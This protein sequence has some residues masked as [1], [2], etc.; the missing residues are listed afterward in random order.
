MTTT[1]IFQVSAFS[2]GQFTG[3]PAAV[4]PLELWLPDAVMQGIAAEN[5]LSETAFF[6]ARDDASYDLRWFTPSVEVDLCGHATL[7]SGHVVLNV[8]NPGID[9]VMFHTRSGELRV[10]RSGDLL[11]LDLPAKSTVPVVDQA[12]FELLEGV[13]GL[14]PVTVVNAGLPVAVFDEESQVASL[15]PDFATMLQGDLNWISVTAPATGDATDF[16]SRYFAPGSGIN[17]D[18]VT[19]S[20]HA[21]LVPY[22]SRRLGKHSLAARQVSTRGGWLWCEDRGGR[23]SLAGKVNSYL[24][25]EIT[26]PNT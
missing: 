22:W 10:E 15:K 14:R 26:I 24:S 4:C 12:Q 11:S 6:V 8:L 21:W 19:G 16:V 9:S 25:G 3:N 20:A 5:N 7:A 13:L 23:V 2:N 17:E 18:P 1:K